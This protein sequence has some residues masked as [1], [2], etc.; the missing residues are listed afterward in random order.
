LLRDFG[1]P[2]CPKHVGNLVEKVGSEW[3]AHRDREADD[4][5][6]KRPQPARTCPEPPTVASVHI[7]GGRIQ[8]RRD[9]AA[10]GVHDD[11]WKET[12]TAVCMSWVSR[13]HSKDPQ[14]KP[15]AK[16]VDPE[17]VRKLA[18]ELRNNARP[19]K[20]RSRDAEPVPRRKRRRTVK[21]TGP[22][23]KVRTLVASL[24]NSVAFGWMMMVEVLR[25]GFDGAVRKACVCDALEYNWTLFRTHLEPLGFVG[26]LD[27]T[28]LVSYLHAAAMAHGKEGWSLYLEWLQWAWS[29]KTEPLIKGLKS[30]AAAI[31]PPARNAPDGDPKKAVADALRYVGNHKDKMNYAEYRRRGLPI[32]STPVESGIKQI[33]KRVKGTE[34]FWCTPG[35]EAMLQVRTAYLSEDGRADRLWSLKRLPARAGGPRRAAA[36]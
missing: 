33:N 18:A 24:A 30:A 4:Y 21:K 22:Q 25:R 11:R 10:P 36:A 5:R 17:R 29:G 9:G 12:K 27:F 2:V 23:K 14:P 13:E 19:G 34:K 1:I 7:D 32:Y 28:H 35:A 31:G 26:I 8:M 20:E 16:F 3:A 15:P 6:E